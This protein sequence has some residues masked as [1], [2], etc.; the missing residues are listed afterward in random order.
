[1][2]LL[3][4]NLAYYFNNKSANYIKK[5][6][7]SFI[8]KLNLILFN[9]D[10]VL[11]NNNKYIPIALET[12]NSL[13]KSNIPICIITNE[14]RQSPKVIKNYLKDRGFNINATTNNTKQIKIITSGLLMLNYISY[15]IN[16][17]SY[18]FINNDFKI[19]K[20]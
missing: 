13:V 9:I 12:F 15:I 5:P 11:C 18:K 17:M 19:Q 14:C 2:N 20:K 16:P 1:M 6:E 4:E 10:G 3:Y 8:S 7:H